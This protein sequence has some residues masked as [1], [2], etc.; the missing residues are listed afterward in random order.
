[1][2]EADMFTRSPD[3]DLPGL[4]QD[5]K[6]FM[7]MMER[8]VC[9]STE[10]NVQL[11]LPIKQR[12]LPDKR[13]AVYCRTANHL[14]QVK[15]YEGR[16]EACL[17]SMSTNLNKGYVEQLSKLE[18]DNIIPGKCWYLPIFCINQARKNKII[19]VFDASARYENVSLNDV[20]YQGPDLNNKLR[21]VLLRFREKPYAFG[22]DIES[23]FSNFRTC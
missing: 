4:S 2:T 8:E 5:D 20:L 6:V 14:N 23:M 3:D 13:A 12:Y 9:I 15:K 16:L 11:P 10:G 21:G 19:L 22:S 18:A 17:V 1:M 7:H